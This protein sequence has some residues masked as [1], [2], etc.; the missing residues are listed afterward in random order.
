MTWLPL[1]AISLTQPWA[2]LVAYGA[3]RWETRS[4]STNYRGLIAI[5]AAKGFPNDCRELCL[6]QPFR[7]A[8]KIRCGIVTLGDIPRGSIL[9]VAALTDCVRI[10]DANAPGEPEY[11]FGN[12]APGR[13]MWHFENATRLKAPVACKGAL[14]VW[15]VPPDITA[16]IESS[17][18]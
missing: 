10:T 9:C 14:G 18:P 2:T 5:H 15:M 11:S 8:L 12:Y 4:W 17:M 6:E 16:Q 1:R 7:D 13:F 3:K